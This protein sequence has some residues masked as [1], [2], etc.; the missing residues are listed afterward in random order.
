[1]PPGKGQKA[2][3]PIPTTATAQVRMPALGEGWKVP[4]LTPSTRYPVPLRNSKENKGGKTGPKRVEDCLFL[5]LSLK[6]GDM[7]E[8]VTW[9]C[10]DAWFLKAC[11][12]HPFWG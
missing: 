4:L 1:M 3:T 9:S 6:S 11:L 12:E 8:R 10:T 5:L 2:L 7:S